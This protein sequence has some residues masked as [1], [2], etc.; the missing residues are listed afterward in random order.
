MAAP[1]PG[2][3][4]KHIAWQLQHRDRYQKQHFEGLIL[5]YNQ[6]LEK[7]NI[8]QLWRDKCD[9]YTPSTPSPPPEPVN[10]AKLQSRHQEKLTKLYQANGE[11][12]QEVFELCK[13]H[14]CKEVELKVT[15]SR[16]SELEVKLG[17]LEA[18]REGL[19]ERIDVLEK[20]N[21]TVKEE[22][23]ALQQVYRSQWEQLLKK[24][25]EGSELI[26]NFIDIK[27][28][29]A[30]DLNYLNEK[31][32]RVKQKNLEKDL[33]VVS[34]VPILM[35]TDAVR[36]AQNV[37]S[38]EAGQQETKIFR[39]PRSFRSTSFSLPIHPKF[40]QSFKGIFR[41]RASTSFS[42][43]DCS[44]ISFCSVARVPARVRHS[45][46]AHDGEVN[47][48]RFSPSSKILATGGSDR[49]VKL[50]DIVG[51]TLQNVKT[52]EGS[53]DGVT[54]I[55]FDPSGLQILAGSYDNTA[56][57]W[58]LKNCELKH[59]LSGHSAK[60]TAAKFKFYFR[61]AVTGSHDRTIKVWDLNKAA[62]VK[63]IHVPSRC[64][65]IVCSDYFIISG[66]CDKKIRLWDCR[67]GIKTDEIPLQGKVTSLDINSD[68]TQLLSCSRD[69]LLKVMDL[70]M[71]EARQELRAEGFKCGADWTKA[72]FS[73]DGNY[74]VAGS[75]DG[76]L[77]VW[78]TL[79]GN[80]ETSLVGQHRS[81][82]NAVSWSLSGE[83]VVSVDRTKVANLWTDC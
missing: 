2:N 65:D 72:I 50:W 28:Q 15:Q 21:C 23:D 10:V 49:K 20:A 47:A 13:E 9:P 27:A 59:T 63:S 57:L 39:S 46:E 5:S 82:I 79:T 58:S 6:L 26:Q 7:S 11:L 51:G 32:K 17:E 43:V 16:L 45:L 62:C 55:E 64:S 76:V 68:R 36:Q 69:D 41:K 52:L 4:R 81:S 19:Q 18:E 42:E 34:N 53:N 48:V 14:K 29:A 75:S 40:L 30:K 25:V 73:P 54:S 70:R 22:Y 60:V 44:P 33:A 1:R 37:S 3:W 83:Y 78:N 8:V 77:Y 66:H 71:N 35:D 61:E 12:A 38:E 24:E 31:S 56:R 74:A 67:S 80:L